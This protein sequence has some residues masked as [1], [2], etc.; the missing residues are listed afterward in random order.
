MLLLI[1]YHAMADE[2]VFQEDFSSGTSKWSYVE[3]TG[4]AISIVSGNGV[5]S[6][7][8]AVASLVSPVNDFTLSFKYRADVIGDDSGWMWITTADG[9]AGY[10]MR[11]GMNPTVTAGWFNAVTWSHSE[12]PNRGTASVYYTF[13]SGTATQYFNAPGGLTIAEDPLVDFT[14]SVDESG[15]VTLDADGGVAFHGV[16]QLN[17]SGT[18][19]TGL[20]K[21]YFIGPVNGAMLIDDVQV[22]SVTELADCQEVIDGGNQILSDFNGDCYVGIEDFAIFVSQWM[23]CIDPESSNCVF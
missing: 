14:L 21:I 4:P 20:T 10:G 13:V 9:T 17:G 19:I 16:F 15:D 11:L 23:L 22:Y 8:T 7:R 12:Q 1:S 2:L 3:G 18:P 6:Y 5:F